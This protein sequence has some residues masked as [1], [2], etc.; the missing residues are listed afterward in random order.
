MVSDHHEGIVLGVS[1]EK[2]KEG[3][4]FGLDSFSFVSVFEGD[5]NVSF[6]FQEQQKPS[7]IISIFSNRTTGAL[8]RRKLKGNV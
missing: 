8:A 2:K 3:I 7:A 1:G 6:S 4:F 5:R